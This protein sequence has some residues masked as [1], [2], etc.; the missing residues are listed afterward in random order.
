MEKA[1][2]SMGV[3]DDLFMGV[4]TAKMLMFFIS[5]KDFDYSEADI[6]R[7]SQ[8]SPRQ[9][10]RALPILVNLGL[11]EKTRTSGRSNMYRASPTSEALRYLE[12]LMFALATKDANS[13][14]I[15][16]TEPAEQREL[17]NTQNN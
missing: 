17:T 13:L 12:Q 15:W 1:N 16:A 8:I 14:K 3:L 10:Y 7:G 4:S 5:F 9:V 6:A 11:V 2:R